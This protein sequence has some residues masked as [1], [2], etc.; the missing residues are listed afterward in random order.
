MVKKKK[1]K[2]NQANKYHKV[3]N[4]ES[5]PSKALKPKYRFVIAIMPSEERVFLKTK[6]VRK[7]CP[8]G[9]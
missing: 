3:T 2:L 9:T 7:M 8:Q 5:C 1:K 6:K 4:F